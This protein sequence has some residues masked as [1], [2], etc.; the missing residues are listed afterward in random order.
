MPRRGDED[1]GKEIGGRLMLR[2]TRG[3]G[4]GRHGLAAALIGV[5]TLVFGGA[6]LAEICEEPDSGSGTVTLPPTDA[7]CSEGYVGE[8]PFKIISGLPPTATIELDVKHKDFTNISSSPDGTLGAGGER[9]EF[10]SV[11]ALIVTGTGDLAGFNRTINVQTFD[12]ETQS[13]PRTLNDPFQSFERRLLSLFGQHFGDP[14]FCTFEIRIG[15]A[16]GLAES[17]GHTSLIRRGSIGSDFNV[18]SFFDVT[19]QIF[20]EG[21]PG[22]PLDGYSGTTTAGVTPGADPVVMRLGEAL[23]DHMKC[24]KAKDLKNPKFVKLEGLELEDQFG[25]DSVKVS[26]LFFVCAPADKE[27]SGVTD[28]ELH[29]CCYKIK[30]TKL[31][32]PEQVEVE[33]QFGTLQMELKVPQLLC[34][35][36]LKTLLP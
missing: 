30:G 22:S 15:T 5:A 18:D 29:M 33:D 28:P 17:P 4:F 34:Q 9:Q 13:G 36:C 1:R 35:P 19:Y 14:D 2:R 3:R 12:T 24:Y 21:C 8:T 7:S 6:A 25:N 31:E 20:F 16:Q 11:L 32:P 27:N 10:D 26:K 23:M